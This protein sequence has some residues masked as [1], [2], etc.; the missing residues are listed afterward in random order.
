MAGVGV[1]VP[2]VVGVGLKVGVCVKVGDTVNVL[3]AV[4][5]GPKDATART[6]GGRTKPPI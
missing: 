2:D 3:V 4:L 6:A 5:L 1:A